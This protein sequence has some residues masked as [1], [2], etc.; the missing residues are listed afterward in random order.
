MGEAKGKPA[1]KGSRGNVV[2][3]HASVMQYAERML[4]RSTARVFFPVEA[5]SQ[6]KVPLVGGVVR[7]GFPSPADD[8][9]ERPLC[10]NE[11]LIKNPPATFVAWVDGDSMILAGIFPGDLAIVDRSVTPKNRSV[12]LARVNNEFTLKRYRRKSGRVWLQAEN[13][14]HPDIP[15]TEDTDFE[16]WGVVQHCIHML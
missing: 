2:R 9:L 7:A 10:M 5:R 8:Y 11:F 12:V 13:P 16:I 4:K 6:I 15:I 3:L 14:T 1:L